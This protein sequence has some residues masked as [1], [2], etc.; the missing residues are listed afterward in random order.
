MQHLLTEMAAVTFQS[1]YLQTCSQALVG[2]WGLNPW[3]SMPHVAS[4]VLYYRTTRPLRFG[5]LWQKLVISNV[6][7]CNPWQSLKTHSDLSDTKCNCT[8]NYFSDKC[9]GYYSCR[10]IFKIYN[11]SKT[12]IIKP[13]FLISLKKSKF[14]EFLILFIRSRSILLLL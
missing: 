6:W 4:T 8:V 9:I 2:V 12:T 13:H 7:S 11:F 14:L 10:S 5:R 3:P 1:T